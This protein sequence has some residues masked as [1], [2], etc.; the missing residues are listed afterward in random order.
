V[1][2]KRKSQKAQKA[3]F[4]DVCLALASWRGRIGFDTWLAVPDGKQAP[5]ESGIYNENQK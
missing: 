2:R 4:D 1:D 3:V 5:L